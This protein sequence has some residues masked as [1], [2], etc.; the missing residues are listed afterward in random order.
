MRDE[1]LRDYPQAQGIIEAFSRSQALN[2]PDDHRQ[3]VFTVLPGHGVFIA[4]KWRHGK[5]PF[6]AIW[7]CM[8]AGHLVTSNEVP[9]G[10]MGYA[11]AADG[12]MRLQLPHR[13]PV[14]C[15]K[16]EGQ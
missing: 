2:N 14:T 8:D 11:H 1:P 16:T 3:I 10:V 6:Q 5:A 12:K 15:R 7:E 4:E 13:S 9:Q